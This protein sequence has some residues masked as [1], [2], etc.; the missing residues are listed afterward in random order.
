MGTKLFLNSTI[1]T[2]KG[3]IMDFI[4]AALKQAFD[5]GKNCISFMWEGEAIVLHNEMN[6]EEVF[7]ILDNDIPL[8]SD[9]YSYLENS[10]LNICDEAN[11][12]ET[13]HGRARN[14][15]VF[16]SLLDELRYEFN[17]YTNNQG[18]D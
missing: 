7:E 13:F 8:T 12:D 6:I 5:T 14:E 18:L 1:Q 3:E 10:F 16:S 15:E 4:T 11:G 17:L 2:N 9:Q